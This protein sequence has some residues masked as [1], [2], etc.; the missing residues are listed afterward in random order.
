MYSLYQCNLTPHFLLDFLL[1]TFFA[2]SGYLEAH[3][4]RP[5]YLMRWSRRLWDWGHFLL[6]SSIPQAVD[7]PFWANGQSLS[8]WKWLRQT[9]HSGVL[10][11]VG[12]T[13][14]SFHSL[15]HWYGACGSPHTPPDLRT[16]GHLAGAPPVDAPPPALFPVPFCPSFVHPI[17]SS[18]YLSLNI[19]SFSISKFGSF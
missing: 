11:M 8:G 1:F 14:S 10:Q 6:P 13:R 19:Q 7:R 15:R 5:M 17:C 3:S 4:F 16:N 12:H 18:K 9:G 2:S